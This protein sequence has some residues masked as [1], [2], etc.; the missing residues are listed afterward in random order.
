MKRRRPG[1][2]LRKT[3]TRKPGRSIKEKKE[4][5]SYMEDIFKTNWD[6]YVG[7]HIHVQHKFHPT[8]EYRFDFAF[9]EIKLAIEMQGY[10]PG[11]ASFVEMVSDYNRHNEAVAL[12][13]TILY[14]MQPHIKDDKIMTTLDFVNKIYHQMA[15]KPYNP[16]PPKKPKGFMDILRQAESTNGK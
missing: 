2:S 15:G 3:T 10:G 4:F 6:K 8:R 12:G 7:I 11:H 9:P 13:W 16:Q 5:E 1:K 14:F